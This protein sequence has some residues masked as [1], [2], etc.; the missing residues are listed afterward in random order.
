MTGDDLGSED[1]KTDWSN[2]D[3]SQ[4]MDHKP[5]LETTTLVSI[6][7]TQSMVEYPNPGEIKSR[8]MELGSHSRMDWLSF[9]STVAF[10]TLSF[11]MLFHS[12]VETA[13]R[14][15][16]KLLFTLAGSPPP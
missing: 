7:G 14:K 2:V 10:W 6:Q 15:V 13:V 5:G 9:S 12:H 1:W 11:V 8:E 3:R 16:H 4:E